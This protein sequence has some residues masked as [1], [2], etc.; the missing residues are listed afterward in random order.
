MGLLFFMTLLLSKIVYDRYAILKES[1][2]F[3]EKCCIFLKSYLEHN[4]SRDV[5]DKVL[6]EDLKVVT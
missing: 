6:F 3:M 1:R 4:I 2:D 5:N